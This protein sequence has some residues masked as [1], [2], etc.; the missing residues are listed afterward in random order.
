MCWFLLLAGLI[1]AAAPAISNACASDS[2]CSLNGV[3]S[4]GICLCDVPWKGVACGI[5]GKRPSC[6]ACSCL[7]RR[8]SALY[9]NSTPQRVSSTLVRCSILLPLSLPLPQRYV[10]EARPA[11]HEQGTTRPRLHPARTFT[12][13]L[14]RTTLGMAQSFAARTMACTISTPRSTRPVETHARTPHLRS[15]LTAFS[16]E[17]LAKHRRKQVTL[18]TATPSTR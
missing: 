14:I 3:C 5:L 16:A 17:R 13:P 4:A 11:F 18:T 9:L 1:T 15:P 12:T 6:A 7:R 2:D 10:N 8:H